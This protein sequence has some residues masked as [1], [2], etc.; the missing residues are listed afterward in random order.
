VARWFDTSLVT[1][2]ALLSLMESYDSQPLS[3]FEFTSSSSR[4]EGAF[5]IVANQASAINPE[6]NNGFHNGCALTEAGRKPS[7]VRSDA[8]PGSSSTLEQPSQVLDE[9]A[10]I[11]KEVSDRILGH[12]CSPSSV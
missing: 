7:I 3:G 5:S 2:P 11:K 10:Q 9:L 1:E 12:F 8:T 6:L 4:A